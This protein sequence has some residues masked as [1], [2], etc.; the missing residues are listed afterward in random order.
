MTRLR[1]VDTRAATKAER[2]T[3]RPVPAWLLC[4]SMFMG[5]VV[6]IVLVV[7]AQ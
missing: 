7:F 6:T 1:R 3:A 2:S 4:A 5:A